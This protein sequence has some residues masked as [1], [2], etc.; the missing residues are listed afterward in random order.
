MRIVFSG[1]TIGITSLFK[2]WMCCCHWRDSQS[3]TEKCKEIFGTKDVFNGVSY[4]GSIIQGGPEVT[5]ISWAS[6]AWL[7]QDLERG[8]LWQWTEEDSRPSESK[9]TVGMN[10]TCPRLTPPWKCVFDD[11]HGYFIQVMGRNDFWMSLF[12]DWLVH[13]NLTLQYDQPV[14]RSILT[15][16]TRWSWLKQCILEELSTWQNPGKIFNPPK[17]SLNLWVWAN[18]S[19]FMKVLNLLCPLPPIPPLQALW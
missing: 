15:Q 3:C 2:T 13:V 11:I 14:I 17:N 7:L 5:T 4:T 18:F 9:P 12:L 19:V 6:I 8:N 1:E 16:K 10:R